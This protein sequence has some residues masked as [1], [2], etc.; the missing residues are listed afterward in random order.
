MSE[1]VLAGDSRSA[2]NDSSF[3]LGTRVTPEKLNKHSGSRP[4]RKARKQQSRVEEPK[5]CKQAWEQERQ[6]LLAELAEARS[7]NRKREER[8]G[9]LEKALDQLLVSLN[10]MKLQVRDQ[11]LLEEQLAATEATANMQQQAIAALKSQISG[12]RS[13]FDDPQEWVAQFQQSQEFVTQHEATIAQLTQELIAARAT[14]DAL[15][16][17]GKEQAMVRAL[18]QQTCREL[19][20]EHDRKSLRL[21]QLEQEAPAL[22]EQILQQVQQA[23]EYEAAVQY[24]RDRYTGSQRYASQLKKVLERV[25]PERPANLADVLTTLH[26]SPGGVSPA[27]IAEHALSASTSK[28]LKVDLPDFIARRRYTMSP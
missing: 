15:E 11:Q 12:T 16:E 17:Q 14:I 20:A 24:W 5:D 3:G 27:A 26:L 9:Q 10:D 8:V 7:T 13:L 21:E 2:Q 4:L 23:S 18:L 22:Q 19:E 25:L 6:M 1:P 28:P